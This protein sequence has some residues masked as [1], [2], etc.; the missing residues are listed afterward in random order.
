M[1]RFLNILRLKLIDLLSLRGLMLTFCLLPLALGFLAGTANLAN[2][3]PAIRLAV[4]DLDQTAAS[5]RLIARLNA[6]G[7]SAEVLSASAAARGLARQTFDGV[8]TINPGYG[9][10]LSSLKKTSVQY[11]AA[12]GSLVTATVREAVAAAVLPDNCQQYLLAVLQNQYAKNGQQPPA[13]LAAR[14]E[15]AAAGYAAGEAQLKVD[16]IGTIAPTP[17]LT[18]VVSDYSMEVIFLSIYAVLGVLTLSQADLRRRLAAARHGLL[19][20]YAASLAAL[21][22]IGLLQVL[23]YTA[24][25]RLVMHAPVQ[26]SDIGLIAAFLALMLGIGQLFSLIG[27]NLR[28]YLS[29]FILL[30]SAIAGGCFFQL[31][32]KLIRTFGQYT[33]H[34]WLISRLKG[35]PALPVFVPLLL[36]ALLLAWGYWLQLRRVKA[37]E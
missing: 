8:V 13:D 15:S 6:S 9:E 14:I 27:R 34:G 24:C 33:P 35:Y 26:L 20:D 32:E 11:V 37:T 12:E 4:V 23:L 29:L 3:D 30:L 36:A 18:Y 5:A 2:Q 22:I 16:Y 1:W 28:L 31:S 17:L 25:M 10:N 19:L 7:W 21:Y